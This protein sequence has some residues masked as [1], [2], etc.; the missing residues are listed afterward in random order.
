MISNKTSTF[1][2]IIGLAQLA[3]NGAV[4]IN[5]AI[6]IL[7]NIHEWKWEKILTRSH[8]RRFSL[9]L[10]HS[11]SHLQVYSR[12]E[13]VVAKTTHCQ[14]SAGSMSTVYFKYTHL[15]KSHQQIDEQID[16][17]RKWTDGNNLRCTKKTNKLRSRSVA[18]ACHI[19]THI[20]RWSLDKQR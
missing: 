1:N 4:Y 10:T 3:M 17:L 15:T 18:D 20:K 12:A 5:I 16:R 2:N 7:K 19:I 9:T 6:S 8:S 14:E 11:R 13:N